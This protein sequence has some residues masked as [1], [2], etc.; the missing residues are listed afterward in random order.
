MPWGPT[1]AN[2][3]AVA[4][5]ATKIISTQKAGEANP[6][7]LPAPLGESDAIQRTL[8]AREPYQRDRGDERRNGAE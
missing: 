4:I 3:K 1:L 6:T 7:P 2:S 5:V 8:E